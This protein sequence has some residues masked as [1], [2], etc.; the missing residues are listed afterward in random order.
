[1]KLLE[2]EWY[3]K[4]EAL[5]SLTDFWTYGKGP[6]RFADNNI[7]IPVT[8]TMMQRPKFRNYERYDDQIGEDMALRSKDEFTVS[9]AIDTPDT[10]K[11]APFAP[12]LPS[13]EYSKAE[14]HR[15]FNT[16]PKF[17]Y[18]MP[19]RLNY[20]RRDKHKTI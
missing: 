4:V 19:Y 7:Y 9:K 1:M 11:P 18:N 10:L 5:E 8:H 3:T 13:D 15:Q 6:G 16:M 2:K 17:K 20:S 12:K 14:Y